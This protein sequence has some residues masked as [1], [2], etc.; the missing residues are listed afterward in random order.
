MSLLLDLLLTI[1]LQMLQMRSYTVHLSLGKLTAVC[2]PDN[3][4]LFMLLDGAP[5]VFVKVM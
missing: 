5:F 3:F 4:C 2:G 1:M